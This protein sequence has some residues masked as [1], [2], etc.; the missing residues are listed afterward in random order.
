MLSFSRCMV[1][2]LVLV[3]GCAAG[4]GGGGGGSRNEVTPAI[5]TACTGQF[6]NDGELAAYVARVVIQRDS[7]VSYESQLL[8]DQN[9]CAAFPSPNCLGCVTEVN[10]SVYGR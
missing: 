4:G 7:G 9:A 6:Q 3:G 5:R 2:S 1:I 10:N 8:A